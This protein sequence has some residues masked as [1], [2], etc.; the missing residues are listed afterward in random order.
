MSHVFHVLYTV[1]LYSLLSGTPVNSVISV[2]ERI[3]EMRPLS[4]VQATPIC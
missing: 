3:R 1:Q 4:S 2:Y